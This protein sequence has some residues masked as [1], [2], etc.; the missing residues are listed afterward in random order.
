MKA[1]R[2]FIIALIQAYR[3]L[4]SPMK[5]ALFGPLG[6]CRYEP[7]CS[8]Y[9]MEAVSR[10][11]VWQGSWLAGRRIGR[12][13]PWGGAGYD[14]VPEQGTGAGGARDSATAIN[15]RHPIMNTAAPTDAASVR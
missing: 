13:H 10:H 4:L 8:A 7:S 15:V 2:Q 6:R 14:P 3:W 1:G 9:A 5:M 12:C 11:G